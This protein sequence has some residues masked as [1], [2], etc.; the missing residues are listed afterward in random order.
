MAVGNPD[1][2]PWEQ[3]GI[4]LG[5]ITFACLIHAI[6]PK[7]GTWLINILGVFKIVLLLLIICAG[8]AALAG[9]LKV[10]PPN[11]FSNVF[12][13]SSVSAYNYIEAANSIIFTYSGWQ[14]ANYVLRSVTP[15]I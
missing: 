7:T 9:H 6:F 1:P 15:L 10:P 3:R 5:A 13:N 12:A 14:G 4:A 11:N 8:F 2:S